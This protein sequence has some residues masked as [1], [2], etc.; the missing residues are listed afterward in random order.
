MQAKS[1]VVSSF[2]HNPLSDKNFREARF[3]HHWRGASMTFYALVFL[4]ISASPMVK[5][6][7]AAGLLWATM[8][9]SGA[10]L[11]FAGAYWFFD[12]RLLALSPGQLEELQDM[13][14]K[15]P[16][17][18]L[19]IGRWAQDELVPRRQDLVSARAFRDA[20][21]R[22]EILSNPGAAGRKAA[23]LEALGRR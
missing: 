20:C 9:L 3:T 22:E 10:L 2:A 11:I 17:I 14:R 8:V 21:I 15:S 12:R 5:A 23:F 4:A 1:T 7:V 19:A 13:A 6:N 16:P 18:A